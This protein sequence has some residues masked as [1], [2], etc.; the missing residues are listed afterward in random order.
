MFSLMRPVKLVLATTLL[1][2]HA[3][4]A[5]APQRIAD[6]TY[7]RI[8]VEFSEPTGF[9]PS[10][11][12]VTNEDS[13]LHPIPTLLNKLGLTGGA[14]LGVAPDQ[15]FSYMA[16]V[17]PRI[18][19]IVD[20]RR[21][22][23]LEITMFKAIFALSRN[24][25]EFLALLFGRQ[26]PADT[27]GWST[28]SADELLTWI[29]THPADSGIAAFARARVASAVRASVIPLD[30][31]DLA[32]LDKIHGEFVLNGP[33]L[34]W[35]NNS[36]RGGGR[37]GFGNY[38]DFRRLMLERD[39]ANQQRNYLVREDD[40]AYIKSLYERNLIIPVTG[41]FGG[42]KA[43]ASVAQYLTDIHENVS[44]FYT[45]NVE[46][47]LFRDQLMDRFA[48]NVARIPHMPNSVL[49][50]S[51]FQMGRGGGTHPLAVPGFRSVQLV[52]RI[53]DFVSIAM[54]GG[55]PNYYELVMKANV[56][57]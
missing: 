25:I 44:M 13:Y 49:V 42:P 14:Y 24:R 50:R 1:I 57:P 2:A 56:E 4:G 31:H 9:F 27:A 6:S 12:L 38:T 23:L 10:D 17:R 26:A 21:D 55:F 39:L 18:A 16:A 3:L 52:Q 43:L 7:R 32:V 54:A 51:Y 30:T 33:A 28:K 15:N 8:V 19:F 46:Q 29:D 20:I 35:T 41:D 5:Q 45:S 34:R 48:A 37:G 53:D 40:W 36:N 47:Y 22:N 11:N